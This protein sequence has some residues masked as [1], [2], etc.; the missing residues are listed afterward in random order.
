MILREGGWLRCMHSV[1][2]DGTK[3]D[4]IRG[5]VKGTAYVVE[6]KRERGSI[7][8]ESDHQAVYASSSFLLYQSRQVARHLRWPEVMVEDVGTDVKC[9][10]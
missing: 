10:L 8:T 2:G 4:S 1:Y 5:W 6:V 9:S 7:L 3:E